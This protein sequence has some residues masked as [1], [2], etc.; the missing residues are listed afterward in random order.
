[1]NCFKVNFEDL[2][3]EEIG[4]MVNDDELPDY[5][6]SYGARL[7]Y[8]LHKRVDCVR[9]GVSTKKFRLVN[10]VRR[11]AGK[12]PLSPP[13]INERDLFTS[14]MLVRDHS[15]DDLSLCR[16]L[17]GESIVSVSSIDSLSPS[18]LMDVAEISGSSQSELLLDYMWTVHALQPPRLTNVDHPLFSVKMVNYIQQ[19]QRERRF[20]LSFSG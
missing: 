19:M 20:P 10:S 8:K 1:M 17:T 9:S 2:S 14:D 7:R 11:L 13:K 4:A 6:L 5:V 15:D 3:D 18:R 12:Q 16:V